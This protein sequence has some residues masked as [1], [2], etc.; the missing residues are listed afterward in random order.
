M[1]IEIEV[2]GHL[3][4]DAGLLRIFASEK[5]NRRLHD[6]EKL[7]DDGGDAAKMAGARATFEAIT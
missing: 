6:F 3:A 5:C 2:C 1:S 7:Q 4:K